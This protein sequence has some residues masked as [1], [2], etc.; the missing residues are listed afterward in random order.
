MQI[1]F[2]V[3][4]LR[5]SAQTRAA[6]PRRGQPACRT[7]RFAP[8]PSLPPFH[9]FLR[10]SHCLASGVPSHSH[11]YIHLLAIV[12]I[13]VHVCCVHRCRRAQFVFVCTHYALLLSW[14]LL[15]VSEWQ[16]FGNGPKCCKII[17]I[18]QV[19]NLA[20]STSQY[21]ISHIMSHS[22]VMMLFCGSYCCHLL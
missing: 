16:H 3:T 14:L 20:G 1:H 5:V 9:P 17:K 21:L 8:C 4:C 2:T 7:C 10:T 19:E 13:C 6:A 11:S 12:C 18:F 15:R 22:A